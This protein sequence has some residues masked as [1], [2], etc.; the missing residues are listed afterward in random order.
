[1]ADQGPPLTWLQRLSRN[2]AGQRFGSRTADRP[3]TLTHVGSAEELAAE[4]AA[5]KL[6]LAA[7]QPIEPIAAPEPAPVLLSKPNVPETLR[8][9]ASEK[10]T[11]FK[12]PA[13][14]EPRAAAATPVIP[15]VAVTAVIPVIPVIPI[16]EAP[17]SAADGVAEPK[18][19]SFIEAEERALQTRVAELKA[20]EERAVQRRLEIERR[21][22]ALTPEETLQETQAPTAG[23]AVDA[24]SSPSS[25]ITIKIGRLDAVQETNAGK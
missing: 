11:R 17:A 19:L 8:E 20:A 21:L 9:A 23:T 12:K 25:P 15:V 16:K 4:I 5:A 22:A 3:L 24:A 2:A 14:E 10:P 7:N 6:R 1:M 18:R 13:L